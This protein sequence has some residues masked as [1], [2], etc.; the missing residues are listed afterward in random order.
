MR[1]PREKVEIKLTG[2]AH[3]SAD[4]HGVTSKT[5]DLPRIDGGIKEKP[6]SPP[7]LLVGE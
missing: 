7:V 4:V 1:K 3:Q 5:R 2:V 6:G